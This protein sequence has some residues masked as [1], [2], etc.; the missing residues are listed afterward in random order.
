M[1]FTEDR[2]CACFAAL[3]GR[4]SD[5][6]FGRLAAA[7]AEPHR[8]YHTAEHIDACLGILDEAFAGD[9]TVAFVEAALWFHDA[10]YDTRAKDN[11]ERSAAWARAALGEAGV[12]ERGVGLVESAVM[13]TKTHV[14]LQAVDGAVIDVD[15]SILGADEATFDRFDAA[16]RME[17]SW[18]PEDAYR[19]G[20]AK[21]LRGFL[22]REHVY[23]WAAMRARFEAPARE[24]LR[25]AIDRLEAAA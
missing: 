12:G 7:Y 21:V 16:I 2:L 6:E 25:R 3:G 5:G 4:L 1:R 18:V 13:A 19:A 11:E 24:N 20:R 10:V 17:Y 15:L 8:R 22:E 9:L 23:S 14:S